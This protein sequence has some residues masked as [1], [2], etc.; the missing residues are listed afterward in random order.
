M[1]SYHNMIH[2]TVKK[3]YSFI[4]NNKA[5]RIGIPFCLYETM[6]YHSLYSTRMYQF[7]IIKKYK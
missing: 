3:P 1:Y 6:F 7:G 4:Q 5:Q 2:T